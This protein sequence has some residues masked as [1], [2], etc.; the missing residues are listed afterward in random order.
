[1]KPTKKQIEAALRYANDKETAADNE[2]MDEWPQ[3]IFDNLVANRYSAASAILAAAYRELMAE[4]K[5][6]KK[7]LHNRIVESFLP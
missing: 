3:E 7:D 4:N 5:E 6:L 2:I 1:M